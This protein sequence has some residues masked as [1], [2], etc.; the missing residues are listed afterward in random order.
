MN[1]KPE[2][3]D[4]FLSHA[5]SDNRSD[6]IEKLVGEIGAV[7]AGKAGRDSSE[8]RVFYDRHAI[9]AAEMWAT[10]IEAALRSSSLLIAIVTPEYLNSEWCIREWKY[11]QEMKPMLGRMPA[12]SG[13]QRI[14]PILLN[15]I[16][17][18]RN[19]PSNN[20]YIV[21]EVMLR[22]YVDLR[23]ATPG[24]KR[25]APQLDRLM[26][27]VIYSLDRYTA[28]MPDNSN[29]D[30]IPLWVLTAHQRDM[31]DYVDLLANA[32]HVTIIVYTADG[33]EELLREALDRMGNSTNKNRF[34]N[35]IQI[36]YLDDKLLDSVKN[37][38]SAS[39]RLSEEVFRRRINARYSMGFVRS[40][41]QRSAPPSSQWALYKSPNQL[42]FTGTLV[43]PRNEDR[44]TVR[45]TVP[46][47]QR[48][49]TGHLYL[50]FKD[51]SADNSFAEAFGE[52]V[53][54]SE[55]D[56][57]KL[58]VGIPDKDNSIFRCRTESYREKVL[59]DRS[60]TSMW[61]PAVLIITW[62]RS[63]GGP[64]S[65]VVQLRT[66]R[67]SERELGRLSHPSSYIYFDDVL[68]ASLRN[69]GATYDLRSTYN[70]PEDAPRVT[71]ERRLEM[72]TGGAFSV[73]AKQVDK[74]RY[75]NPDK[76][77]LFFYI[78]TAE[79]QYH[80]PFHQAANI[81]DITIEGLLA[82]REMQTLHNALELYG[83]LGTAKQF[84]A[85]SSSLISL[86]LR[87]HG[88]AD[89]A[90]EIAEPT[91]IPAAVARIRRKMRDVEER[92][93]R[94]WPKLGE[95]ADEVGLPGLQY[96]QFF[97]QLLDLYSDLEIPGA[98][99]L[100]AAVQSD[101]DR[102]TAEEELAGLYRNEE[103]MRSSSEE[104]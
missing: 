84:S 79:L 68:E 56:I 54:D 41:L 19:T 93:R 81:G 10:R 39:P 30:L 1:G 103:Y 57:R 49:V 43:K 38:R 100:L 18:L 89:L 85:H 12:G 24:T 28:D 37:E 75:I 29:E 101:R 82:V 8:L 87:L 20:S 3:Y 104:T 47:P 40:L 14:F 2:G 27:G 4:I 76:E 71:V 42:P 25:C 50:Q 69:Q 44:Y 77:N 94:A 55:L 78:Y 90:S 83:R 64:P 92:V 17:E 13:A 26:N 86:N 102:R 45:L 32:T 95:S 99:E 97:S 61:L 65:L 74:A 66:E 59:I 6:I 60:D 7:Y 46:S 9:N 67:N 72:E 16:A 22:E 52:V 70:L 63:E 91:A 88:H 33:L 62:R 98:R 58:P 21:G 36:V 96:R 53:K 23:G 80:F 73:H 5:S 34:W 35:S 11:F 31:A 51:R 15:G 48:D